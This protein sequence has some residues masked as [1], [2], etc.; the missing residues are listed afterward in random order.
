MMFLR[1]DYMSKDLVEHCDDVAL[2]ALF[3]AK[4]MGLSKYY[5]VL[6]KEAALVHDLGK[7][8]ISERI[9]N[10][11]RPL[12]LTERKVV[13]QHAYWGYLK[14]KEVGYTEN[15]CQLVLTHHG[16]NNIPKDIDL[17]GCTYLLSE[18][19][20]AAD[21]YSAMTSNRVYRD[22]VS[23]EV[24]MEAVRAK[25]D[26]M[27]IPDLDTILNTIDI[28]KLRLTKESTQIKY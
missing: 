2:I 24:A 25:M 18:I 27:Y 20:I 9:L 15:I 21:I 4:Q 7:Y 3:I 6:L 5:T 10:A 28:Q 11:K 23:H 19:L 1:E 26:Y 13:D 22:A 14:L 16:L 8:Y 12:L 17:W